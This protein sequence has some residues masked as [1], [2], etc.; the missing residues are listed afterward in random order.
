MERK[1]SEQVLVQVIQKAFTNRVSAR[2]V[3]RLA[4]ALG[5]EGMSTIQI[6][7]TSRRLDEQAE[8]SRSQPL[9][10]EYLMIWA[11]APYEK[12]RMDGRV[13]S[14]A[15]LVVTAINGS[16]ERETL[17]VEPME[18]ECE[19]TY[20]RV[21]RGLKTRGLICMWLVI[22]DAYQGIQAAV[23]K[24]FLGSSWQQCRIHFIR[25]AVATVG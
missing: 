5:I 14:A 4:K 6:S 16:V 11:D 20:S 24:C 9:E 15:V 18:S 7:E 23:K 2:K 12:I 21:F 25:N 13:I 22:S 1:R 8:A 17:A 19:A 3:E 10:E